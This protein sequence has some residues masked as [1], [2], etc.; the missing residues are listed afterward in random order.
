VSVHAFLEV[1]RALYTLAR[2]QRASYSL[3]RGQPR[4][5]N[6][7]SCYPHKAENSQVQSYP[8]IT[9]AA[10]VGI[11]KEATH[12]LICESIHCQLDDLLDISVAPVSQTR[13]RRL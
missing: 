8:Q 10:A 7:K 2:S 11:G 12:I 4:D 5:R 13:E 3:A 6:L 1:L 9:V